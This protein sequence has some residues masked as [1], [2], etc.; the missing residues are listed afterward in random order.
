LQA[1]VFRRIRVA[2]MFECSGEK[3]N[4]EGKLRDA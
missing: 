2:G 3:K 1:E 4:V